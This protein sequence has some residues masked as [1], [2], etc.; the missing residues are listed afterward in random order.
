MISFLVSFHATLQIEGDSTTPRENDRLS[1]FLATFPTKLQFASKNYKRR[2]IFWSTEP[3]HFHDPSW[4]VHEKIKSAF[5]DVKAPHFIGYEYS[6]D[7]K[8]GSEVDKD[9][10]IISGP[11]GTLFVNC[12]PEV[13]QDMLAHQECPLVRSALLCVFVELKHA[14][15]RVGLRTFNV[16]E[17]PEYKAYEPNDVP[18][19]NAKY[20][21]ICDILPLKNGE[22]IVW[23]TKSGEGMFGR[24][25][26][27]YDKTQAPFFW[28]RDPTSDDELF[29]LLRVS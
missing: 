5:C 27:T 7:V 3:N 24:H 21:Y 29:W 4:V 1:T 13:I 12:F 8:N 9:P 20:C 2:Q 19:K 15:Q 6:I 18:C 10:L 25:F 14:L 28:Q 11:G 23:K 26:K 16:E 22:G 17:S